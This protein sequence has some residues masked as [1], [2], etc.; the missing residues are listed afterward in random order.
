M[1]PHSLS[2]DWRPSAREEP[3]HRAIFKCPLSGHLH[4]HFHRSAHVVNK[5]SLVSTLN[6]LAFSIIG[7]SR[8]L[9]SAPP[10]HVS[11]PRP[12]SFP[13]LPPLCAPG[14]PRILSIRGLPFA[15]TPGQTL[16]AYFPVTLQGFTVGK[17]VIIEVIQI[18]IQE[19]NNNKAL[20]KNIFALCCFPHIS[21]LEF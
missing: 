1:D 8:S 16:S 17:S 11:S 7:S 4:N 18:P 19:E 9:F 13:R 12:P 14:S 15:W 21:T 6:H 10:F 3:P 20:I 2:S 5:F